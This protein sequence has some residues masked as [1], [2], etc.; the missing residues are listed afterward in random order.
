MSAVRGVSGNRRVICKH[1][2]K[3]AL[4]ETERAVAEGIHIYQY[5]DLWQALVTKVP[6]FLVL[7]KSEDFFNVR[8]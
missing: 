6:K 3:M 5:R 8:N 1:Y 7:Y 4:K 2:I